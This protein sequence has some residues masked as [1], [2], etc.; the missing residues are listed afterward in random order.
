MIHE[1]LLH[2]RLTQKLSRAQLAK[3]AGVPRNQILRTEKGGDFTHE[4]L[5]RI[6]PHLPTI[7]TLHLGPTELPVRAD[8]DTAALYDDVAKWLEPGRRLRAALADVGV[9]TRRQSGAAD[10]REPGNE[11]WPALIPASA[12]A[13]FQDSHPRSLARTEGSRPGNMLD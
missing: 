9:S 3:L 5:L 11:E 4:T 13:R 7:T 1:E 12:F 2:A 10:G 8:I 6:L